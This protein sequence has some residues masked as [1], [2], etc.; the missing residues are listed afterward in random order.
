MEFERPSFSRLQEKNA[1]G[2]TASIGMAAG[3]LHASGQEAE[4]E[5]V[6]R[7]GGIEEAILPASGST[8]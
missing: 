3:E 7:E 2:L 6:F 8:L 5:S 1:N 4:D